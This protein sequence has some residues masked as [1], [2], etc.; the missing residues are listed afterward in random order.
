[1]FF[2]EWIA[3]YGVPNE[4]VVDQGG[5]FMSY[6]NDL[7]EQ[8]GIDSRAVGAQAPWQHGVTERHGGLLGTMW[9]KMAYEFGI[10]GAWMDGV[11]L[12]AILNAK[13]STMTR[14]GMTLE[15]S[16]FRRSLRFTELSNTDD[17]QVLMS[18]LDNHGLAWKA[19]QI[20]T[21]AKVILL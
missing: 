5:E 2:K 11:C 20:R 18:V 10:K 21:A 4:V 8:H 7:F 3:H 6:L 15:Q 9:R 1:M 14:N 17:D 13:N 19:S 16:V 12:S